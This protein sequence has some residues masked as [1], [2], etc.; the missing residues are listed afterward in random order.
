MSLGKSLGF[1]PELVMQAQAG[2]AAGLLDMLSPRENV[3]LC[4]N[5]YGTQEEMEFGE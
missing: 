4:P 2:V 1:H 3:I 5:L